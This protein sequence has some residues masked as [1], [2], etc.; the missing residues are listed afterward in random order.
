[1]A[2]SIS[3]RSLVSAFSA[4]AAL[5]GASRVCGAPLMGIDVPRV[6]AVPGAAYPDGWGPTELERTLQ[7]FIAAFNNGDRATLAR[8]IPATSGTWDDRSQD[9]LL[10]FSVGGP[11]NGPRVTPALGGIISRK[12]VLDYCAARHERRE[13]W[14][15]TNLSVAPAASS[16][17]LVFQFL[18]KRSASDLP[19]ALGLGTGLL[20]LP[21]RTIPAWGLMP[22]PAGLMLLTPPF[23]D[24]PAAPPALPAKIENA[25]DEMPSGC[26][27]T[28]LTAALQ[29]FFAAFNAG[30]DAALRKFIPQ[31]AVPAGSAPV[32]H[33]LS[34]YGVPGLFGGPNSAFIGRSQ[35]EILAYFASRHEHHEQLRLLGLHQVSWDPRMA[36]LGFV[37]YIGRSADDIAP[38]VDDGKMEMFCPDFQI[39]VWNQSPAPSIMPDVGH[40]A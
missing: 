15:L 19:V 26:D 23:M 11:H 8:F 7:E 39:Q 33:A 17:A 40:A 27:A 38:H 30:D 1:M 34:W 10:T 25:D 37:P 2:R 5:L 24:D 35:D 3:R 13:R 32:R 18:L 16:D 28:A 22:A 20:Y 31:I 4:G 9:E 36:A 29:R 12:D 6:N 14:E 21:D